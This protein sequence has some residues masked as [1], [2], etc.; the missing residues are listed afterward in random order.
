MTAAW[1]VTRTSLRRHLWMKTFTEVAPGL[2]AVT[3]VIQ[4]V[5]AVTEAVPGQARPQTMNTSTTSA[6]PSTSRGTDASK[7]WRYWNVMSTS[8]CCRCLEDSKHRVTRRRIPQ[9]RHCSYLPLG[10]P[11]I[12]YNKLNDHMRE[13]QELVDKSKKVKNCIFVPVSKR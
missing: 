7:G 9:P 13:T 5:T 1:R 10:S 3:T 12:W 2:S 11:E 4:A 8:K 6:L